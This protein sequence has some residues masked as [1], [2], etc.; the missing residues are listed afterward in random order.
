MKKSWIAR[1]GNGYAHASF[2]KQGEMFGFRGS[3]AI[4]KAI[5]KFTPDF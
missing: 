2:W 1:K 3:K 4:R 5:D